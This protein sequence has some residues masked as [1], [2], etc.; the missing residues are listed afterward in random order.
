MR[1]WIPLRK[2]SL[3]GA[4][5]WVHWS[6][7]MAVAALALLSLSAPIYALVSIASY[8]AITVVHEA[9]HAFIAQRL[10]YRVAAIRIAIIHGWCEY[11]APEYESEAVLIAWGGVAAQLCI[12]IPVLLIA[13]IL[14]SREL[15]YFGPIVVFLG[16]VNLLIALAN[17]VPTAG[18]D[19]KLAWRGLPLLLRWWRAKRAAKRTLRVVSKRK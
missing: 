19:G 18:F 1:A 6:V 9:G 10:G 2:I 15:Y 12:A 3:L 11:E 13:W 7:L 5:V 14:R 17:L 8:L 4:P 16:Y